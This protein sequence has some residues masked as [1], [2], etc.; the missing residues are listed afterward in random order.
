MPSGTI[1]PVV[2]AALDLASI[3]GTGAQSP[4]PHKRCEVR[5]HPFWS[6]GGSANPVGGQGVVDGLHLFEHTVECLG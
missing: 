6:V 2:V 5:V 3:F 1:F 4:C